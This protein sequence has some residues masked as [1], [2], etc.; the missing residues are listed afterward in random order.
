MEKNRIHKLTLLSL[1]IALDVVLSPLLRIEGMAPMSSVMNI[2]A[3]VL[4]GPVYGTLMAF[5]CGIIRMLLMGIPPLALTGAVF[6]AFFAGLFYRWSGKI[7]GSMIGEIIG[8][9]LIGSLLSYPV[10]VWFTGSQQEL[11]W[12]I[13]T[14]RFIGATLIGSVIAFLVLVKLKETSI[15]KKSQRLFWEE[16]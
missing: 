1:M 2:I 7:I 9:G 14:P 15:F 3:G 16:Y 4:L 6:G 5:V 12:F 13:Y 8:T 10:M 11:Y